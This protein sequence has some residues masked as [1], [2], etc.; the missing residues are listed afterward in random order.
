[1]ASS[2]R[3]STRS[4]RCSMPSSF[5]GRGFALPE[6]GGSEGEG[7]FAPSRLAAIAAFASRAFCFLARS[8]SGSVMTRRASYS[9]SPAGERKYWACVSAEAPGRAGCRPPERTGSD[10]IVPCGSGRTASS[11]RTPVTSPANAVTRLRSGRECRASSVVQR[12]ERSQLKS[13]CDLPTV[14]RPCFTATGTSSYAQRGSKLPA[15]TRVA[16]FLT[17]LNRSPVVRRSTPPGVYAIDRTACRPHCERGS[18]SSKG[19]A[20]SSLAVPPTRPT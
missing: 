5:R 4:S 15:K 11:T 9:A 7:V 18:R 6:P 2:S 16:V 14:A 1:M 13:Y 3:S 20:T 10:R 12:F 19:K 8:V 17:Q